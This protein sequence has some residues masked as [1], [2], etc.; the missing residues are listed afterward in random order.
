MGTKIGTLSN[1][2]VRDNMKEVGIR[3]KKDWR[4][5]DIIRKT[6]NEIRINTGRYRF[7]ARNKKKLLGKLYIYVY[8]TFLVYI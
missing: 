6:W 2:Q 8:I 4:A 3:R 5:R 7:E 1:L